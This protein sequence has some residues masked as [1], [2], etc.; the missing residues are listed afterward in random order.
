MRMKVVESLQWRYATKKFDPNKKL[1]EAQVEDLLD[2][3]NLTP[4]SYGLQPLKFIRVKNQTIRKKLV[5]YSWNQKQVE[6]ASD[7]IVICI[8]DQLNEEFI[9]QYIARIAKL[10]NQDTNLPRFESFKSMLM[11]I[12][13]W[14][15]HDYQNWARKQAYIALGNLMTSCAVEKIDACPMEGFD[16][17]KYDEVLGLREIGLHSVLVC[18]IG[19]RSDED[20][21]SKLAKVRKARHEII[22]E[23]E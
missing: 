21:N 10:R 19:F 18:P 1:T 15:N 11:K 2:V 3:L 22:I 23:I 7:L 16:P 8:E 20:P 4:T 13:D 6:D 12:I 9:D 14:S 5:E 17:V